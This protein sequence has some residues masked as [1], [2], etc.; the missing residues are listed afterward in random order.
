MA[1]VKQPRKLNVVSFLLLAAVMAALYSA[2]KFGPAYWRKWKVQ[3]V[4]SA[5]ANVIYPRRRDVA[6]GT[7][8][9]RQVRE[10]TVR[11]LRELGITDPA[12][13]VDFSA[14]AREIIVSADYQEQVTHPF[15]N[16]TTSLHFHPQNN[17][18]IQD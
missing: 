18:P 14:N 1:D 7:A 13:R 9:L 11:Q 6:A 8:D 4:L 16:K 17:T 12:L 5:T 2:V 10:D 15:V 3:G